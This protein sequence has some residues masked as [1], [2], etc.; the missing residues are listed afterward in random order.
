MRETQKSWTA[1]ARKPSRLAAALLV[2]GAVALPWLGELAVSAPSE[3]NQNMPG[4]ADTPGIK[5]SLPVM[6][7]A[8][9]GGT[10]K[11][12]Q[13]L[14]VLDSDVLLKLYVYAY[15]GQPVD[16][17]AV[18]TENTENIDP[19]KP[20]QASA[21]QKQE[22]D[23][24]IQAAKAHPDVLIKVSDIALDAYDK[25]DQAYPI[26][27]RLFIKGAD[28]YFDNSPFHYFYASPGSFRKLHCTN[29]QTIATLDSAIVNYE[30]FSM[31]IVGHVSGSVAKDKALSIDLRK[32]TLKDTVGG[33]LITQASGS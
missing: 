7:R 24:L 32:I 3:T 12:E 9:N 27:N 6:D 31:D 21:T 2:C 1:R 25:A 5:P 10:L 15:S 29:A 33:V 8:L 13:G 22:I 19:P 20:V 26:D 4:L 18:L 16:Y 14:A 30:H 11:T 17:S 28:Y 23:R